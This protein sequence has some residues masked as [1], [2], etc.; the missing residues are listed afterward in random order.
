M[1]WQQ[2]SA[3]FDSLKRS[4]RRLIYAA[5][6]GLL[7]W[8]GFIYF[9]EPAWQQLQQQ[10]KQQQSMVQQVEQTQHQIEE[11]QH[12][13]ARDI[14]QQ[15]REQVAQLTTKLAQLEQELANQSA[16]FI[17]AQRMVPM[18][19][20][21]LMAQQQV[22]LMALNSIAP[23]VIAVDE[24]QQPLL[25]EHKIRVVLQGNYQSLSDVLTRLEQVPWP[26]GW[27]SLHYQ[28]KEYPIAEITI[29]LIT[30]GDDAD[31]IQL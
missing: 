4:E 7:L 5:S 19:R 15:H 20:S 29:E 23:R 8:I 1:S 3:Q 24:Q 2:L 21:I 18:L 13:L 27:A 14:N 22:R 11:L 28:V 17:G 12:E 6:I 25:Y 26:L 16:H 9:I 31:F 10:K 30:V